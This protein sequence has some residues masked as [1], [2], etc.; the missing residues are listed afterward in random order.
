[1]AEI[2]KEQLVPV[3]EGSPDPVR[4]LLIGSAVPALSGMAVLAAVS[5]FVGVDQLKS[6]LV[7]GGLAILALLVGP[8]IHQ[9]CR[10][11][12]PAL[13]LGVAITAYCTVIGFL[14]VGF[15]LLNDTTWLVG[16]FA[17]AGVFVSSAAWAVGHM[18]A[19][20]GLRQ[21]LYQHENPTAER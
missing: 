12:D 6:S 3:A 20:L 16:E 18:R 21:L 17:A 8:L 13:S 14:W 7:G 4:T 19:A 11:L 10:T 1:M 5:A 15:S 2:R 9:L